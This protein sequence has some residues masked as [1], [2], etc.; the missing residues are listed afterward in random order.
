MIYGIGRLQVAL[1]R[2]GGLSGVVVSL[3]TA[4]KDGCAATY[5][6][7][8]NEIFFHTSRVGFIGGVKNNSFVIL[9]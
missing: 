9:L 4:R 7:K 6:A 8:Q 2:L 1:S 3:M 5:K